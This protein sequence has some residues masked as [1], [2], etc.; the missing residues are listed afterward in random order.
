MSVAV[1]IA[2]PAGGSAA[3][4]EGERH[5][6]H[7]G[8]HHAADRRD[9]RQRRAARIAQVARDELA[10][11][12]EPDHEE[13]DRQQPVGRPAAQGQIQVQ[14]QPVGPTWRSASRSYAGHHGEFAQ[15]SAITAATSSSA[16]PTVS[17]RRIAVMREV[18]DH[19]PR[20]NNARRSNGLRSATIHPSSTGTEKQRRPDF[21]AHR[22]R[23]LVPGDA[24]HL[25]SSATHSTWWVN[26]NASNTLICS[27]A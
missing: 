2:Q 4:A 6:D 11:E 26:G 8:H 18:S 15:I 16:P 10:L 17:L 13:E 20:A 21:P 14:T 12:L 24:S 25:V 27:T 23:S 22:T 3:L 5:E 7:G 19:D 1:G 9:D